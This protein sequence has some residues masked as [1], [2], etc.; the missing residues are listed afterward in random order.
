MPPTTSGCACALVDPQAA[1]ALRRRLDDCG[2]L[3]T[4]RRA[5]RA[6]SGA[7]ALP[8]TA[9]GEAYA[10]QHGE[11]SLAFLPPPTTDRRTSDKRQ[12]MHGRCVAALESSGLPRA[13]A[14]RL[15][16]V[17]SLPSKWEKLG[18]VALFAPRGMFES[19]S[20]A[21]E[22]LA[23]LAPAARE[24]LLA[25]LA[26]EAGAARLGVQGRIGQV[27][28][29]LHR[30][31]GAR[32]VWPP[33]AGGW[34]SFK[35]NGVLYGLDVCRSMFS[36]GNGTEKA[37]VGSFPCAGETV[38]D[39]YAGIGYFTLPY[40]V[41]AGA[42]HVHACEWDE[43]ALAALSRNVAA[44]GVERRCTVHAGDN[45]QAA[46]TLAG[47]AHRVNLG[48]IPSSE[49]GWPVAVAVLLPEGGTLHVHACVGAGASEEDAWGRALLA[50]L[51]A[52]AA[53]MGRRGW[54]ARLLHLERVKSY[55]PR[56]NHVVADVRLAPV[57]VA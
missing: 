42:A 22:A 47:V 54:A 49:A 20:G 53:G 5:F 33:G 55:A 38:V 1:E 25:A 4:G 32:L 52:L 24:S 16:P 6:E 36:S 46:A 21:A 8:L 26:A 44:N 34:V 17:Q 45:V 15:F 28:E 2:Y 12:R 30:K 27:E 39:L 43:D 57:R 41:H 56:L 31:S 51:E 23:A 7:V 50:R 13:D 19:G 10:V 48:L 9:A 35:E 40:L 18:D 3:D 11:L 29:A 14:A 37:R